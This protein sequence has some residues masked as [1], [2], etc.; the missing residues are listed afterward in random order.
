MKRE[1]S[2]EDL[3]KV[4]IEEEQDA[5]TY[6]DSELS[7]AQ[8]LAMD[9]YYARPYGDGSEVP[10][11]SQICTHD[12]QDAANWVLPHLLRHFTQS[13]D[14]IA[15]EDDGL[16]E[17][18][19]S[20]SD[21]AAYLRHLLFKDNCGERIIHDYLFDG[22]IQKYGVIRTVWEQADP[23][24]EEEIE[25]L[26]IDQVQRYVAD[27]QYKLL[28]A[29]EDAAEDAADGVAPEVGALM[30]GGPTFSIKVQKTPYSRVYMEA[31]APEDFR[32]SRRATSIEEA[33]Y[34]GMRI[35]SVYLADLIRDHPDKKE[36]LTRDDGGLTEDAIGTDAFG[37]ERVTARFPEELDNGIARTTKE[38]ERR[39]VAVMIEYVKGDF[40]NDGVV[41]LRRVKRTGKVI[42]ENEI[43]EESEFSM[44]SP[45]PVAHRAIGLAM[46][47]TLIDI[48]RIRT[49][50]TRKAMDSLAQ[51]L[52]PRTA[53]NKMAMGDDPSLLDRLLDHEVG[54]VIP[55]SG[56]PNVLFKELVT[57]DV[58]VSA[59]QAIEYWDRRSE[60]ASGVNR[61]AMGIQ[62]QAITD[63][64]GGIES[65][66]A[67]ANS[68][69]EQY[70]RWAAHG[71]ETALNKALRLICRH[72]DQERIIKVNGRR[73]Q[74]DPRR[75][76]DEMTV[77][78][79]VG[80]A[81]EA[82]EKKLMYLN[83]IAGK[84]EMIIAQAGFGNPMVTPQQYRHTLGL[85]VQS[86]GFR[87]SS[88]FFAEI[89]EG[90]QPP[91]QEDPKA[92][93]AKGKL[94]LAQAE[95]QAK[96][97]LSQAEAQHRAQLEEQKLATQTQLEKMRADNERQIA[98]MKAA[99]E[100]RIAEMKMQAET[101]LSV[102]RMNAEMELARWQAKQRVKV[103]IHKGRQQA[104]A[105]AKKNGANGLSPVRMGG[106]VG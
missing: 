89:P 6:Y 58:S 43:E 13:E 20:L 64:K 52:A 60:E 54:D 100:F 26:S 44:W 51:S 32:I 25:G 21:A 105:G 18:D 33:P 72:Q 55:V 45:I 46:A 94:Q 2:E 31:V 39:K 34:H 29:T 24:P 10:N 22:L 101:A 27:P 106:A 84:Q 12:I 8:A 90:W 103:E 83:A 59:F 91:P 9:R 49:V 88:P 87:D 93:E 37:D 99:N 23:C 41:E 1:V 95:A 17:G 74:I 3:L 38:K 62:P 85:M 47:D 19:Q 71:I 40:D 77:S 14:L 63:T 30:T 7:R 65:L 98:E 42:L 97:Q 53:I 50:L 61:H 48:Q 16:E 11:R 80:M 57:P 73:I 70:A 104:A 35:N 92:A 68:R 56:D 67:A 5:V 102:Q 79:H 86:M 75:W 78:V 96:A 36:E 66:Q 28:A 76:S 81:A 4:L 69:I 15:V 82:R